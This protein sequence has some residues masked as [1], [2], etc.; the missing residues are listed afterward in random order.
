MNGS[1]ESMTALIERNYQAFSPEVR[2]AARFVL[3]SPEDVALHSMRSVAAK[4]RVHPNTMLRLARELGFDGYGPFQDNFRNWLVER[5][6]ASWTGRAQRLRKSHPQSEGAS[7]IE[8]VIRQEKL[9]LDQSFRAE[10]HESLLKARDALI[11]A[12]NIYL[13]GLRSLFPIAFY[14]HYACRMFMSK[15]ILLTG[16]GGTFADDLRRVEAG[17]VLVAF[18]YRPY[19]RDT[20]A[21]VDFALK[22]GASLIAVTDS[23]LSP[24]A[25]RDGLTILV[26]N[27][28]RS[29]FPTLLPALAIAQTLVGLLVAESGDETLVEIAKSEQQLDA[30]GVYIK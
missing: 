1:D 13:L 7:F 21:A 5:G 22:R 6:Q 8:D 25:K 17:D 20:A 26:P 18:S 16:V 27:T 3:N 9:N 23:P 28:T 14:T 11:A 30:F 24:I 10:M 2:K 29:F 12:P 4:A 15:T 19:A